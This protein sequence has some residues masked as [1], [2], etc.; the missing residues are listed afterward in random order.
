MYDQL[1]TGIAT[2]PRLAGN[3]LPNI[4]TSENGRSN[5]TENFRMV[6]LKLL[7]LTRFLSQNQSIYFNFV[8]FWDPFL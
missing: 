6:A 8:R 4:K 7:E 5:F 1:V 3:I 2:K